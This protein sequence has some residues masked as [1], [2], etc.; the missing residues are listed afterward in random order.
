VFHKGGYEPAETFDEALD[1]A[2]KLLD[3]GNSP[4]IMTRESWL[5]T[6]DK[7]DETMNTA[8]MALREYGEH[9]KLIGAVEDPDLKE[10]LEDIERSKFNQVIQAMR[11]L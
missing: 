9:C 3:H 10:Q 11:K 7:H 2:K 8:Y 4:H 1:V 5:S 6:M